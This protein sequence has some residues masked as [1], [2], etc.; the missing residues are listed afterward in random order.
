VSSNPSN[1]VDSLGLF[2]VWAAR[3]QTGSGIGSQYH[4]EFS[5]ISK[6]ASRLA[7]KLTQIGR[8][9]DRVTQGINLLH[10]S[11]TGKKVGPKNIDSWKE[12]KKCGNLDEQ[13]KKDF[14]QRF[15]K[16][17][18]SLNR[19]DAESFLNDS[20]IKYRKQWG[21]F[22]SRDVSSILNLADA[23]ADAQNNPQDLKE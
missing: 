14:E 10:D 23:R 16:G 22:Y 1:Y 7:L 20:A 18:K 11:L 9:I 13:L 3:V 15:G 2:E 19:A 5:P 21:S 12:E 17:Y 6:D 8:K 4:F